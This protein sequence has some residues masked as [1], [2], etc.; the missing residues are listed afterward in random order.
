MVFIA[1][2]IAALAVYLI[3]SRIYN[4]HVFD[5]LRYDVSLSAEEVFEGE[6]IFMYEELTNSKSLPI[7]SVRVDTSLPKGMNFRL[8]DRTDFRGK[9]DKLEDYI[10]SAFVLRSSQ[11]IK[12]RWRVNCN[13]RGVYRLGHV[14][15]VTNDLFGF[16]SNSR[17]IDA[18]HSRHNQITVL[19]RAIDLESNFTSSFYHSGDVTVMR[20]LLSDPLLISGSRDYT[21]N[22]P[23]SK[24]N[25]NSTAVHGRLMV[26]VEDFTEQHIFNLILNMQSRPIELHPEE[27]SSPE[28]IEMCITV[29]ASILD[30]ISKDNIPVRVF[31]NTPPESVGYESEAIDDAGRKI[32][33]TRPFRGKADVL[34]SLRLLAALD[35]K[36]SC[37]FD[38]LLDN[39]ASNPYYYANGGNII[40]VSSYIDERMINFHDVLARQGVNVAFYVTTV[41]QNAIDVPGNI[42]VW[43]KTYLD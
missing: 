19:P 41:N 29:C 33:V 38:K 10:Q 16:N 3:Q 4:K 26:N 39:V 35:M 24:I 42:E 9:R 15:M 6:D 30:K 22:D 13:K 36:I 27:P 34:D 31:A 7:P 20:S 43:Y 40:V 1:I 21:P 37:A 12:R 28:Y 5:N 14:L 11:M 25:W 2:M 23:F 17:S 18:P 8:S 32:L